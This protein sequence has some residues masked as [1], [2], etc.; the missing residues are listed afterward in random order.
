MPVFSRQLGTIDYNSADAVKILA[1]HLRIM[2]EELEY[3]LMVLDSSNINEIALESTSLTIDNED[4]AA[5]IREQGNSIAGLSIKADSISSVVQEQ[6]EAISGLK[7]TAEDFQLTVVNLQEGLANT[8]YMDANGFIFSNQDGGKVVINGGQISAGVINS[9]YIRMG[10]FMTV[11]Q[12]DEDNAEPGGYLGYQAS[13]EDGTGGM[14]M[15]GVQRL[16]GFGYGYGDVHATNNGCKISFTMKDSSKV[17]RS[18]HMSAYGNQDSSKSGSLGCSVVLKRKATTTG[19]EI[20]QNYYFTESSFFTQ[21]ATTK[22]T[23]GN[24]EQP[25]GQIYCTTSEISVSDRNAKNSIEYDIDPRYDVLWSLLKPCT[26]K[27]NDGTS[28]RTHMFLISQDVEEAIEQAG[29]TSSDFA[30]FIKS[31]KEDEDG[32]VYALRYEEFIPLC[33]RHIQQLEARMAELERS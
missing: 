24:A 1:N 12:S 2:Q 16:Y 26:G 13:S 25:W 11:Y 10:G 33:I 20:S 4:V 8:L 5:I 27:Y 18:A 30:A 22:A 23:L 21:S 19:D 9:K 32:Y 28:D 17:Y 6:G 15:A 29:L 3:R 7:Q 14:Q 31:P